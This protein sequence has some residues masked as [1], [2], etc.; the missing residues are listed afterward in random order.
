MTSTSLD[1][2]LDQFNDRSVTYRLAPE[3]RGRKLREASSAPADRIACWFVAPTSLTLKKPEKTL[4]RRIACLTAA[5]AFAAF[6]VLAW[7]ESNPPASPALSSSESQL[8]PWKSGPKPAFTLD[9]LGG[10]SENLDRYRGKVVIVHFFA[11]WCEPCR[12]EI[13]SLQRLSSRL[14]AGKAA[15]LGIDVAEVDI[16]VRR[17]FENLPV[18]FPILLDRDRRVA[19][20]WEVDALP[21]TFILDP[22]LQPKYFVEGDIDWDHPSIDSVV[23]ELSQQAKPRKTAR[24]GGLS[25]FTLTPGRH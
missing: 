3:V 23:A 14:P 10:A 7:A 20:T 12:K 5:F 21:A 18:N 4:W 16:R 8:Q 15:I 11:T 6:P 13:S 2:R 1:R 24:A 22:E 19:K 17:F 9:R 25:T